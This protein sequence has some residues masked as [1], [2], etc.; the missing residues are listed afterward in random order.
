MGSVY[1]RKVKVCTTCAQRLDTTAAHQ[2]CTLAGR[3]IEV[4]E[5]GPWWILACGAG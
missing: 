3:A 5:Q 1:R 2:A 4:R